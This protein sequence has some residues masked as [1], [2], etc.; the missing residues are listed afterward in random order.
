MKQPVFLG[1][2]RLPLRGPR[3]SVKVSGTSQQVVGNSGLTSF[4]FMRP[5]L[6]ARLERRCLS[7]KWR[8]HG[9]SLCSGL[10]KR[11]WLATWGLR[12]SNGGPLVFAG[13]PPAE[14]VY[15]LFRSIELHARLG[16][17]ED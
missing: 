15:P 13:A 9:K 11:P 6:A 1:S 4:G 7:G 10:H 8:V 16:L 2:F 5:V 3:F 14:R 12:R 17:R